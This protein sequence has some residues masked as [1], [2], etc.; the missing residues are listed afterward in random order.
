[1]AAPTTSSHLTHLLAQ[2]LVTVEQHGRYRYYRLATPHVEGVLE[3][4]ARLAPRQRI[5]SL[6]EHT[7][8]HALRTAR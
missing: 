6:R 4:L 5:T 7:R 1:M 3:A 2:G 8:A